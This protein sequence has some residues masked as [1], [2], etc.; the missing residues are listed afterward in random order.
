M[1]SSKGL[2]QLSYQERLKE[3]GLFSLDKRR[4][5][6]IFPQH[7]VLTYLDENMEPDSSVVSSDRI[8][9]NGY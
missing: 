6:G 4:L 9:S 3:L 2:E 5:R 7:Q 1:S 8:K